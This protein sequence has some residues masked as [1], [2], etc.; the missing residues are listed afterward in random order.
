MKITE[1]IRDEVIARSQ[2]Y[3]QNIENYDFW[4]EHIRLVVKNAL[5]LAGRN[6][7]DKEIVELAALLH[8]IALIEGG[9][10][11]DHHERGA[12]ISVEILEKYNY[13]SDKIEKVRKCV[14]NHRS[15]HNGNTVEEKC[16]ADADILAHFDNIPMLFECQLVHKKN[17][18]DIARQ[19]VKNGLIKDFDDLSDET[20]NS[21]RHRFDNILVVLFG[22]IDEE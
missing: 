10:K 15:S 20:R 12:E 21:T 9:E 6:D 2:K 17:G 14:L 4:N 11:I 5:N 8:D 18:L 7:A 13:P 16:V 19:N 22:E 1:I 3:R